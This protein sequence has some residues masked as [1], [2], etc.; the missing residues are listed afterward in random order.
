MQRQGTAWRYLAVLAVLA[1]CSLDVY[2]S[3]DADEKEAPKPLA[4]EIVQTWRDAGANVGWMNMNLHLKRHMFEAEG[5]ARAMPVFQF[6]EWEEGVLLKLPDPRAAFGLCL[7]L[8]KVTDAGLKELAGLK[9]LRAL[10]LAG[11]EREAE[12]QLTDAGLKELASLKSLRILDVRATKVTDVG[13]KALAALKSLQSLYLTDCRV[14]DAGLKE[15]A[16]LKC[17][18]ILNLGDTKVTDTGLKELAG[19]KNLR[20]LYLYNTAVT[21]ACL[22]DLATLKSL[23]MLNLASCSGVTDAGLKE[24]AA[25]KGLKDLRLHLT[26]V[27]SAGAA[28]LRKDL[29][30]CNI[31]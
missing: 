10:Y 6:S 5:E 17:L 3:A 4:P 22:K 24:L 11:N 27:T 30:A 20:A 31:H 13:L 12:T 1:S 23:Q 21:D 25:L 18:Q 15:L 9:S 19:L 28:A 7:N 16:G 8:T 29:P 26:K 14:T 2:A